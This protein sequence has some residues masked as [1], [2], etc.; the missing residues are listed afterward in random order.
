LEKKTKRG[1]S[2]KKTVGKPEPSEERPR[3]RTQIS[4]K[5]RREGVPLRSQLGKKK[6][7]H[8]KLKEGWKTDEKLQNISSKDLPHKKAEETGNG[9]R[10]ILW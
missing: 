7:W 8:R 5:K 6:K 10:K 1:S 9:K 2:E 3:T 4:T